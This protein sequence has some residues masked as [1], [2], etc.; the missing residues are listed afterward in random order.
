LSPQALQ[1]RFLITHGTQDPLIPVAQVREQ[2]EIL[3]QAGLRIDWREFAKAHIIA[4]E[5][6]VS[7]L[8]SFVNECYV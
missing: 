8:R 3:R 2:M 1:Q 7:V 6:E 5:T 4:G